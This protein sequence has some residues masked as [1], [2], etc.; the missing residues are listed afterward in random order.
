[1]ETQVGK[2]E[3]LERL[4]RERELFTAVLARIPPAR[5]DARGALGDWSVKDIVAHLVAH[6]QR[7]LEELR[8][9]LR[10]ERLEIDH[11]ANDAFNA[12]AVAALRGQPFEVVLAIWDASYEEV[13]ETVVALPEETFAPASSVVTALDDSIDGALA[14]NTYA[15][16]A[17]HRPDLEAWLTRRNA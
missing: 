3:L 13:V 8:R 16:Y 17:E 7:A 4:E 14:N 10:G 1:M 6:E 15:H 2:E 9:A 5:L 11:D 12:G